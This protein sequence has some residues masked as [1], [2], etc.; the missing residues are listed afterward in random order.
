LPWVADSNPKK[1]AEIEQGRR[2]EWVE[3]VGVVEGVEHLY[4]RHEFELAIVE[5]D[6]TSHA[7]VYDEEGVVLAKMVTAAVNAV[8]KPRERVVDAARGSRAVT[9]GVVGLGFG[10]VLLDAKVALEPQ[11]EISQRVGVELV[12]LIAVRK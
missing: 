5:M 4:A 9:V 12:R 7:K 2:T 8:H 11:R 6:R 10:G 3:I 1:S